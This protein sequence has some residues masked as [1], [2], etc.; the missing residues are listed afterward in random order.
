MFFCEP[1][2]CSEIAN[3]KDGCNLE[4]DRRRSKMLIGHLLIDLENHW[5]LK[6]LNDKEWCRE[7]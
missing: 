3:I 4:A 1:D 6:C 2:L 5:A 7:E